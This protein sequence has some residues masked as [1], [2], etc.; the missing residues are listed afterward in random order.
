MGGQVL[1][2]SP[3]AAATCLPTENY[4][5]FNVGSVIPVLTN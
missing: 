5:I 2:K 3:E 1:L 4:P